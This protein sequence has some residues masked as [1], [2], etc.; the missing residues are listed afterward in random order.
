MFNPFS[1]EKLEIPSTIL[2]L[3]VGWFVF[4]V[5]GYANGVFQDLI[6]VAMFYLPIS[7]LLH[8]SQANYYLI[9]VFLPLAVITPFVVEEPIKNHF[10]RR[11]NNERLNLLLAFG[12]SFSEALTYWALGT[13]I[14]QLSY[15]DLVFRLVFPTH[16]FLFLVSYRYGRWGIKGQLLASV[17]HAVNNGCVFFIVYGS[18]FGVVMSSMVSSGVFNLIYDANYLIMVAFAWFVLNNL[19]VFLKG[20]GQNGVKPIPITIKEAS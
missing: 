8:L 17:F 15:P 11:I 2:L 7:S 14:F 13:H 10:Y 16:V 4:A 6:S 9:T 19:R 12:F 18:F 1:R 20:N 3:I 5:A